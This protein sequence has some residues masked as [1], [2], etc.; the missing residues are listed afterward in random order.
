MDKIKIEDKKFLNYCIVIFCI[1]MIGSILGCIIETS[2]ISFKLQTLEIRKGLLYGPFVQVYGMGAVIYYILFEKIN[3]EKDKEK[4]KNQGILIG[5]KIFLISMFLGGIT[6]YICSFLLEVFTGKVSWEYSNYFMN[7]NGRT[8][9]S[10]MLI[11]GVIGILFGRFIYPLFKKMEK[12]IYIKWFRKIILI[13]FIIMS[14]NIWISA[15]STLRQ[16]ERENEIEA[17]GKLDLFLD[18]YYPDE[19]LNKIYHNRYDVE[20]L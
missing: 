15:V 8:C 13:M 5:I 4:N 9:I 3:K 10:Y 14:F 1:F 17:K 18:K 2:L 11:W 6:E 12:V 16:I 7:F 20:E 19:L